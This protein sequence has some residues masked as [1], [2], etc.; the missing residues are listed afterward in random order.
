[1]TFS[2][3]LFICAVFCV[4]FKHRLHY[5]DRT[6]NFSS[7]HFPKA[8]VESNAYLRS[9]IVAEF[10]VSKIVFISAKYNFKLHCCYCNNEPYETSCARDLS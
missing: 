4:L 6:T 2:F 10:V 1:M 7:C 3:L 8:P 5:S 9:K